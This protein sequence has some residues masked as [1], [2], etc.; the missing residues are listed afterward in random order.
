MNYRE[1][2]ELEYRRSNSKVLFEDTKTNMSFGIISNDN[3]SYKFGWQ[4]TIVKPLIKKINED[5]FLIGIDLNFIIFNLNTYEII[6]K[7]TLD[8][9][10]FDVEFFNNYIYVIT[11]LEII[12]IDIK[13][14]NIIQGFGL[15]DYFESIDFLEDSIIVTCEGNEKVVIE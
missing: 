4:S 10:F 11:Q 1:V 6:F 5:F 13:D 9:Y 8:Y 14:F 7:I 12:K 3:H 15:P 2:S